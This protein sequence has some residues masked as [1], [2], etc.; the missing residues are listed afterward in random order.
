MVADVLYS[1]MWPRFSSATLIPMGSVVRRVTSR[2][3]AAH[4]SMV[5]RSSYSRLIARW[6]T[7]AGFLHCG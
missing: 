2:S 3:V 6:L 5:T 7:L 4:S 1:N